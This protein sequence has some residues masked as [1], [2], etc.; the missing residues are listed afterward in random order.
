MRGILCALAVC[1]MSG[2]C[3]SGVAS[4]DDIIRRGDVNHD[5]SVNVSDAVYLNSFLYQGGAAPPCMNE[6]DVNKDGRVDGS[7][8]AFLLSYLYSGGPA[9]PSP[10]PY[11]STCTNTY[12]YISCASSC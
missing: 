12:P 2:L 5:A 3:W 7:D 10:G 11:N 4:D 1:A 8:S 9:P 6:A